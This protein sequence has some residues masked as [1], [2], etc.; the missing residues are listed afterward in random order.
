[1]NASATDVV[2]E[3]DPATDSW[4]YAMAR[5]SM[6]RS[7]VAFGTYGGKIYV[8]GGEYLD[9]DLVGAYRSLSAFDPVANAWTELPPLAIPRG[10]GN[11]L[12]AQRRFRDYREVARLVGLFVATELSKAHVC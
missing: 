1:M 6:P 8:A 10:S 4:G 12:P 5:M 9:N 7:G 11:G 2:E 3:Y